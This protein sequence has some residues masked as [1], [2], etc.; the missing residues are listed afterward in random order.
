MGISDKQEKIVSIIIPVYNAEKYLG[1]CLNSIASQTYRNLEIILVNDGSTD[2]SLEICNNYAFLDSRIRIIDIPNGGVSNARNAGLKA[3]TGEYIE[4]ADA[5]DVLNPRMVEALVDKMDT[6]QSD[7]VICGFEMVSL[8]FNQQPQDI[9]HFNSAALGEE[10]VYTQKLFLEKLSCI[11]WRTSLL[12]CPWNKMFRKDI[13]QNYNLQFPID[14]SLGEDFCFNIDYFA[15][16]NKAVILSDEL[17][18]YMQIN[19]T[20][21]TR[22]YQANYF[23]DQLYLVKKFDDMVR[24]NIK[25]SKQEQIYLAEYMVA[26]T[27]QSIRHLFDKNCEL[28]SAQKKARIAEI[29]NNSYVRDAIKLAEYVDNRYLWVKETVEKSDVQKV[30][31]FFEQNE[32]QQRIVNKAVIENELHPSYINKLLVKVCDIILRKHEYAAVQKVRDN[33]QNRGIKYTIKKIWRVIMKR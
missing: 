23:E 30:Y 13:I 10:C 27:I 19:Q 25:P 24:K 22:K 32:M 21:L 14:K 31:M 11:L 18:Y 3:A 9:I 16:V 1:Y 5:D 29:I 12:E 33:L 15:Y 17:Y 8:N 26:K 6:Y 2:D 28:D 20:A 4:F 7:I